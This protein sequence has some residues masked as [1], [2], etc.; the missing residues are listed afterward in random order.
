MK[1]KGF[2]YRLQDVEK[3]AFITNTGVA[4]G[5]KIGIINHKFDGLYSTARFDSEIIV[6]N[7]KFVEMCEVLN[8]VGADIKKQEKAQQ[9]FIA[10]LEEEIREKKEPKKTSKKGTKTK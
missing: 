10:K 9:R 6:P 8:E 1:T 7:E 3:T 2:I 5:V 4:N